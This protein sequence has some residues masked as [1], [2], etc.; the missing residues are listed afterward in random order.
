[1]RKTKRV[2]IAFQFR[3]SHMMLT[4]RSVLAYGRRQGWTFDISPDTSNTPITVWNGWSGDGMLTLI[5]TPAE[6]RAARE[7]HIP[8]VNLSGVFRQTGLPRVM[9][10]SEAM[11]RLAAEHL[12]ECGF[13]RFGYYG[14]KRVWYSQQRKKGFMDRIEAAGGECSVL[15]TASDINTRRAWRHWQDPLEAW[16]GTLRPPVGVLTPT[17]NRGMVLVQ[18]CLRLGLRVPHDVAVI[19]VSNC[20]E[21][22]EAC[23]VPLSSISRSAEEVGRRAAELLDRLMAGQAPPT[24]DVLVPPDGVVQRAS[25][26]VLAVEDPHV[27][28]AAHYVREHVEEVFG[29]ERLLSVVPLSRQWLTRRFKES[30]GVAPYEFICRTRV[31]RAKQL[32]SGEKKLPMGQI[33]RACGF[34]EPRRFRL[35]FQRLTGMTPAE[36]RQQQ[37]LRKSPDAQQAEP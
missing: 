22:C 28:Q 5:E 10:D 8:V 27:A 29:I 11:G 2:A 17:E 6:A 25:T 24:E 14:A 16:L 36:Y 23:P 37:R 30:L 20:T 9:V 21:I 4:L 34:S 1:M 33:S 32:L 13:R 19:G 15:D 18:A 35:V 31:R 12:L 7:M 3:V 26:D